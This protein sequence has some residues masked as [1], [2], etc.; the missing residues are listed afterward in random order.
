MMSFCM[1]VWAAATQPP[2]LKRGK[3]AGQE[4]RDKGNISNICFCGNVEQPREPVAQ[5][6]PPRR[7]GV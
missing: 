3:K 5:L 7:F 2:R 6:V 4:V 1:H